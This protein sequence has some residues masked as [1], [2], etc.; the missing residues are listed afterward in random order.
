MPRLHKDEI[1]FSMIEALLLIIIIAIVGFVGWFVWHSKQTADKTL[2][3]ATPATPII[4]KQVQTNAATATNTTT[5]PEPCNTGQ[6]SLSL[7]PE[8]G[9]AGTYYESLVL[10][11]KSTQSCVVNGYPKVSLLDA[12]GAMLGQSAMDDTTG[13]PAAVALTLAPAASAYAHVGFLKAPGNSPG[14][15]TT[16]SATLRVYPPG[17]TAALLV[18]APDFCSVSYV[19]P[20]L[21]TQAEADAG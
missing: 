3:S 5:A 20:L 1:G 15:C 2:T 4:K 11:N 6:L 9:A 8:G 12:A 19:S 7:L 16:T 21:A 13:S 17:E 18:S 14:D 10:T